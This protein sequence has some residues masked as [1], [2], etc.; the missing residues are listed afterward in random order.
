MPKY[1]VPRFCE[2]LLHARHS[3][4]IPSKMARQTTDFSVRQSVTHAS[5]PSSGNEL[6]KIR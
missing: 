1:R 4:E 3:S 5:A 2:A 6:G